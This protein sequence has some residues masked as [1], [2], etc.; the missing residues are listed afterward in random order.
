MRKQWETYSWHRWCYQSL[1]S[2]HSQKAECVI[3]LSLLF[4]SSSGAA[5]LQA[6]SSLNFQMYGT[7]KINIFVMWENTFSPFWL[8][9][10]DMAGELKGSCWPVSLL[11][12]VDLWIHCLH[13]WWLFTEICEGVK[14][15]KLVLCNHLGP[16]RAW[17]QTLGSLMLHNS[18]LLEAKNS[19]CD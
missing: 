7:P 13:C 18:F 6:M 16:W 17:F 11:C 2:L 19:T 14:R 1:S 8:L 3:R 12:I 15:L 9:Y 5:G 10:Q 4:H